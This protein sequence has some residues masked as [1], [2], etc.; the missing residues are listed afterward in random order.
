MEDL[1]ISL[2]QTELHWEQRQKNRTALAQYMEPLRG[3]TDLILLP[4]MFTTGFTMHAADMAEPMD[5][6]TVIWMQERAADLQAVLCGSFIAAENGHYYNRLVWMRPDGSF[7][8]YDKRHRF[9]LA[10]EDQHYAAGS[11]RL[12]VTLKGWRIM[13]LIC[14]DLRFPVWSRNDLDYHLLLYVANWPAKR[15]HAWRSLLAARAIENQSYTIGVNRVGRDEQEIDYAGD[16][17]VLDFAGEQLLHHAHVEQVSTIT[18][19]AKAQADFR[20]RFA[21]LR[22]RDH[23]ALERD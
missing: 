2:L 14:Y 8:H 20:S 3:N 23:F 12:L 15:R 4:E 6:A 5:G 18:L 9:T 22:D 11:E 10:G 7:V 21:F 17:T 13:P 19:A 1:R 16:S